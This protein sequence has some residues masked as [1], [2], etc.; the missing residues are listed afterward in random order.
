MK[1]KILNADK[2]E[3]KPHDDDF[4]S[5]G[6]QKKCICGKIIRSFSKTQFDWNWDNHIKSHYDNKKSKQKK[7]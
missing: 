4:S 7:I 1:T 3:V 2:L 5:K 6:Y